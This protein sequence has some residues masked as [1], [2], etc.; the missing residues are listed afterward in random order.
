[1]GTVRAEMETMAL[2]VDG[3][4]WG[5]GEPQRS[6]RGPVP[7]TLQGGEGRGA[8]TLQGG[9]GLEAV[10]LQGGEGRGATWHLAGSGRTGLLCHRV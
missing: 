10:T 9:E 5:W 8:A 7:A 2:R 6:R 3:I 1:M 4:P